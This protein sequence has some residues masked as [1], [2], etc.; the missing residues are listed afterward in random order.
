MKKCI[1]LYHQ[2]D[3]HP[4]RMR[5]AFD[6]F[7]AEDN[8]IQE[9][10]SKTRSTV[11]AGIIPV[12]DRNSINNDAKTSADIGRRES[13]TVSRS[14]EVQVTGVRAPSGGNIVHVLSG[15]LNHTGQA[16]TMTGKTNV[17]DRTHRIKLDDIVDPQLRRIVV[18]VYESIIES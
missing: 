2:S 12:V 16:A 18:L 10:L 8:V 1:T 7:I 17:D 6:K 9:I 4:K 3:E 14:S 15:I 5:E 11:T 13:D